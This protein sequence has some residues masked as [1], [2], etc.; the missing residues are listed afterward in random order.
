MISVHDIY[1]FFK[2][3]LECVLHNVGMFD[4][5]EFMQIEIFWLDY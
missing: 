3:V 5:E 4:S 2:K 1:C